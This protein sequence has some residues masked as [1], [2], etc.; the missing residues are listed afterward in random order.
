MFFISLLHYFGLFILG[1]DYDLS[2]NSSKYLKPYLFLSCFS[3]LHNELV[4]LKL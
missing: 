4:K 2:L 3:L 1:N